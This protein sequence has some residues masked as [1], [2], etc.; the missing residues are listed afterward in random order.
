MLGGLRAAV[1]A[2]HLSLPP[3]LLQNDPSNCGFVPYTPKKFCDVLGSRNILFAGDSMMLQLWSGLSKSFKGSGDERCLTQLTHLR[4]D[5]LSLKPPPRYLFQHAYAD[6]WT[7]A[8]LSGKYDVIVLNTAI[9]ILPEVRS[10][11][12]CPPE[13]SG[14][15]D[16]KVYRDKVTAAAQFLHHNFNGTVIYVSAYS[17]HD[18]YNLSTPLKEPPA[19]H[20]RNADRYKWWRVCVS[21]GRYCACEAADALCVCVCVCMCVFVIV[22]TCVFVLGGPGHV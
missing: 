8:V 6:D 20:F 14:N 11:V 22:C 13:F 21:R 17:G 15:M 16:D 19:L 7:G 9:H 5:N 12:P 4:N 18:C 10:G 2:K 3:F 1:D